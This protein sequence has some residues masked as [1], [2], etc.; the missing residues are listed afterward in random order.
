MCGPV[1][2][3][4]VTEMCGPVYK[5]M[6]QVRLSDGLVPFGLAQWRDGNVQYCSAGHCVVQ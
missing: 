6:G 3:G 4:D 2:L 5:S 1:P